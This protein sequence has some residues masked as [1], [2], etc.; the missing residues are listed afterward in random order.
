MAPDT[1]SMGGVIFGLPTDYFVHSCNRSKETC[2]WELLLSP[3]GKYTKFPPFLFPHMDN[4]SPS[5]FLKMAILFHVHITVYFF[6]C[7][8]DFNFLTG[9]S[10]CFLWE[11]LSWWQ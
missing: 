10:S 11:V 1:K 8:S 3:M 9:S 4:M 6:Q 7:T 5:D 2:Y